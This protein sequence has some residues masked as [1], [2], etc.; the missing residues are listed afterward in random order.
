MAA[1]TKEELLDYLAKMK[2]FNEWEEKN[3]WSLPPEAA[4]QAMSDLYDLAPEWARH[5][6]DDPTYEGARFMLSCLRRLS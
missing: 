1:P 6:N 2:R 3:P 4:I 5:Q